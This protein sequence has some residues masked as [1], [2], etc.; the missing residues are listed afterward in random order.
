VRVEVLGTAA[1]LRSAGC[2]TRSRFL[3]IA[4][5]AFSNCRCA[6][7]HPFIPDRKRASPASAA[8][9]SGTAPR[10][11]TITALV[12]CI[13]ICA[14]LAGRQR[15]R[16]GE[17]RTDL[18]GD[19]RA[20]ESHDQRTLPGLQPLLQLPARPP[21][22][23]PVFRAEGCWTFNARDRMPR[24]SRPTAHP[25]TTIAE[26][27]P[28][29]TRVIADP[30]CPLGLDGKRRHEVTRQATDGMRSR[31][32]G[33]QRTLCRREPNSN[34]RSRVRKSGRCQVP[35]IRPGSVEH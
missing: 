10:C 24:S 25:P 15:R 8:A 28:T 19:G 17:R 31:G 26:N 35:A 22:P 33:S 12:T 14:R 27:A 2:P 7:T 30:R 21:L 16:D 1:N 32:S 13:A 18:R 4:H 3:T 6:C 20:I 29:A 23:R 9:A 34:Y 11:P 5:C